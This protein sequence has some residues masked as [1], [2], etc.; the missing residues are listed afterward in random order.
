LLK[1]SQSG[2]LSPLTPSSQ[3]RAFWLF[4]F[5]T[6]MVFLRIHVQALQLWLKR[7]PFFRLPKAPEAWITHAHPHVP[8]RKP[9]PVHPSEPLH[10]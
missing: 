9:K 7:V 6:L 8:A 3:R 1:T 10:P 5:M 2:R 4:P